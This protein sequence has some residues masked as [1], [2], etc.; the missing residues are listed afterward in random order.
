MSD[1]PKVV[2]HTDILEI[3]INAQEKIH[4]TLEVYK[5]L[6]LCP[7]VQNI[8]RPYEA[9]SN[10]L[11]AGLVNILLAIETLHAQTIPIANDLTLQA[12]IEQAVVI[13]ALASWHRVPW[14]SWINWRKSYER[15]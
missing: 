2:S 4:Q 9:M 8:I 5:G 6:S 12:M 11:D 14:R 10:T 15:R 7:P 3:L 1:N 13:Q